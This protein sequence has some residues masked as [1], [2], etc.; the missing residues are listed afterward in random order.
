MVYTKQAQKDAKEIAS[1]NLKPQAQRLL[2]IIAK[3]PFQNP[4]SLLAIWSAP[5]RAA[6]TFSTDWFIRSMTPNT[7]SRSFGCGLTTN[8]P[9][10]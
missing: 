10:A 6:S 7:P 3:N 2:D 5:I 4:K 9:N 1:S 8:E